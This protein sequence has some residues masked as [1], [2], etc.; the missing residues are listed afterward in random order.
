MEFVWLI[1]SHGEVMEIV[2]RNA[3]N[4]SKITKKWKYITAKMTNV[5]YQHNYNA[6]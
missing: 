2:N 6:R 3:K 5:L 4:H 1:D